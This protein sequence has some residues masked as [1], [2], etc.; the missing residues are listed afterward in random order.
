MNEYIDESCT[1]Q[2]FN[3]EYLEA[4]Y[5]KTIIMASGANSGR[6][7]G[8]GGQQQRAGNGSAPNKTCQFKLVLLGESAVGKL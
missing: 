6:T 5:T 8:S 7:G 2:L 3:Y 1:I 4:H